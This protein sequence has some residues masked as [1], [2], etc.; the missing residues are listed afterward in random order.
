MDAIRTC[1]AGLD[2]HQANV[3][4][5]LLK[6]PL[7]Q[8]PT[9]VI[10]EF[11]TVLSGLLEL[12]DWLTEEGCTEI[13]MESTGIFWQP[14]YNV[15]EASCTITLANAAHIK[16]IKGRK[17]DMKDAQWIAELHRCDLIRGSFVPPVE[18]R[19]LRDLTRYRKKLV[20]HATAE[21]N[22]ILKV[23]EMANIKLSTFM[24]D[25]FGVSGRLMLQALV[26]GEV[27]EPAQIADL[28][29][30]S[31][32]SKIPQLVSALNGRVTKHHRSMI[33]RS[34]KHLEFLEQS[35]AELE[36]DMEVYF[37]PYQRQLELLDS[38]P[39][40]GEHTAKIILAEL[41][42]DMSVFPTEMHLSSWAGLSP[43][44]NESAGKKKVLP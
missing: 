4:V 16:A 30:A 21:R 19:E 13:A 44:N 22:R 33:A 18:I 7:H 36:A 35:I 31:L 43:G 24:S 26:N 25:V 17:T 23:L 28:A 34:L 8:K 41:G 6:G 38:I 5:C 10:R 39:G 40:V 2:V 27:I 1:C 37:A 29:K 12:A 11:S 32:R 3:V 42:T 9:K 20:G 14:V 15:L